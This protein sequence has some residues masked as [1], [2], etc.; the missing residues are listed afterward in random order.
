MFQKG[1]KILF[2]GSHPDDIELGCGALIASLADECKIFCVTLS[3]NK[4]HPSHENLAL[5]QEKSLQFLKIPKE[6]IFLEDFET[7]NFFKARQEIC[8]YLYRF[9]EKHQPDMVFTHSFADIHQDHEVVTK[10]VLRIFKH[11][12]VV[13]FEI[14][15][16]SFKFHPNFFFEVSEKEVNAKLTALKFYETYKNKNYMFVDATRSQFLRHGV[17]IGKKY[18]E[19]FD[20]I[21][22]VL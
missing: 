5:E 16:S 4:I 11:K 8:D 12:T 15:P 17:A 22:L 3:R 18:A 2:I 13:G 21:R 7:R 19:A 10:E 20:I 1:S 6:N 14:L 9:N